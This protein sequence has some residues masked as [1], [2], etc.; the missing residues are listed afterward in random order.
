M[1][2]E[3]PCGR[4]LHFLSETSITCLAKGD[5]VPRKETGLELEVLQ[6]QGKKPEPRTCVHVL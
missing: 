2:V 3:K 4:Y 6:E 1:S 5:I